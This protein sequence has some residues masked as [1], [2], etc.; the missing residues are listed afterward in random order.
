MSSENNS[1]VESLDQPEESGSEDNYYDNNLNEENMIKDELQE[2]ELG[3]IVEAKAKLIH[4]AKAHIDSEKPNKKKLRESFEQINKAK[5]KSEPKEYSALVKPK[6]TQQKASNNLRYSRDPRFDDISGKLN[7]QMFQENYSFVNNLA[8]EYIQKINKLK[9]S[10]LF[11]S[12]KLND[13]Q[14]ELIKKQTN[15]VKGWRKSQEHKN[16]KNK[17]KS[18]INTENKKRI[19]SG[20]N[21]IYIKPSI[22]KNLTK[23]E[24]MEKRSGNKQE[25][26]KFLKRKK[27]REMVKTRKEEISANK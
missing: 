15:F 17:I 4:K 20:Q 7:Q 23:K 19:Q 11:K 12:K 3:K 5:I 10:K 2:M 6:H 8:D 27:H 9:K 26:K 21:P 24:E 13:E 16:T 18:E 25:M 1:F 14:Y 22:I